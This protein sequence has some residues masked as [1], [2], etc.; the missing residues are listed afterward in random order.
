MSTPPLTV[1]SP[2]PALTVTFGLR[3]PPPPIAGTRSPGA[4]SFTLVDTFKTPPLSVIAPT[5]PPSHV[6]LPLS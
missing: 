5:V 1:M 6:F 4:E 3:T 2:P